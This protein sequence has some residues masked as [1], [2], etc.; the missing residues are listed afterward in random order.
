MFKHKSGDNYIAPMGKDIIMKRKHKRQIANYEKYDY[1]DKEYYG[2]FPKRGKLRI[3]VKRLEKINLIDKSIIDSIKRKPRNTQYYR[4]AKQSRYEYLSNIFRDTLAELKNDWYNEYLPAIE[5]VLT[6]KEV[7]IST[8]DYFINT[9]I[10]DCDEWGEIELFAAL[11]RNSK[12]MEIVQSFMGQFI[13]LFASKVEQT[14]IKVL[15]KVGYNNN[16]FTLTKFSEFIFNKY[17]KKLDDIK[18][19]ENFMAFRDL[20]NFLKHNT[21]STYNKLK[22]SNPSIL[23]NSKYSNGEFALWFIKFPKDF[24]D[25]TIKSLINFFD[26][27]C[28]EILLENVEEA[29][30]NYDGFFLNSFHDNVEMIRNPL[31]LPF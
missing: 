5:K 3:D 18:G 8:R 28:N 25:D 19:I 16:Y 23:I 1:N 9:G 21:I 15:L 17:H 12:Y 24:I 31:G 20:W 27:F 14:I 29:H 6:P 4:P 22:K 13:H 10:A 26:N 30:W 7:G 2:L 11:K